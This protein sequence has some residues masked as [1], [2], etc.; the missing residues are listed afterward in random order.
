AASYVQVIGADDL[1]THEANTRELYKQFGGP[2]GPILVDGEPIAES[3]PSDSPSFDYQRVYHDPS[4][5]S[6]LTGF[7]SLAYGQTGLEQR[8]NDCLSGQS[9]D[10]FIERIRQSI[11]GAEYPVASV[12]LTIDQNTQ[13]V[14]YEA[15]P[16]GVQAS[17]GVSVPDTGRILGMASRPNYDTSLLAVHSASEASENMAALKES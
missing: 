7:Y 11:T 8:L 9:D 5:Y 15:L 4:L 17:V 10:L 1:R 14:A 13:Q 2:R 3:V 12:A 6:G 16:G